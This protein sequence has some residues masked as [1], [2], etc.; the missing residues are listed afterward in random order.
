MLVEE[1]CLVEVNVCGE[2][3]LEP[4]G[5]IERT[6]DAFKGGS[7]SATHTG[8]LTSKPIIELIRNNKSP[9]IAGRAIHCRRKLFRKKKK[10]SRSRYVLQKEG[11]SKHYMD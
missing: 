3:V 10:V 8:A 4:A 9:S 1:K 2:R 11:R 7:I 5:V 6:V